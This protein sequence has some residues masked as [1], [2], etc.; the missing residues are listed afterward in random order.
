MVKKVVLAVLVLGLFGG[1]FFYWQRSQADVRELNKNLPDGVKVVKSLFGNEY[2]VVNK[3]D[4]YSFKVPDE[5]KGVSDIEYISVREAEGYRG[6]SLNIG[7]N[8][9]IGNSVGIDNYISGGEMKGDLKS[10]AESNFKTFGLTGT[11]FED[12]VGQINV[13]KAKEEIHLLGE[14]VYFFKK[15]LNIYVITGGSEEFIKEIILN[16]KW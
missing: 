11:F 12:V 15:E 14:Q 3:L 10:W 9:G 8:T 6:T 13:V 5:W 16:G 4:G 7:G 1:G 2:R